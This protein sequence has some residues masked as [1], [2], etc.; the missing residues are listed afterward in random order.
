L[1]GIKG[2]EDTEP[3]LEVS[4]I[5]KRF[6]G[7]VALDSV[8]LDVRRSEIVGIV[9][10]NGAGKSTLMKILAGIYRPDSGAIR[11]DGR[12][13]SIRSP[14]EATRLGI[15]LIHQEL[16][17]V[18]SLDVAG[19]IFLGRE[20]VSWGPLKLIDR[21]TVY[22]E[23]EVYLSR[24]GLNLSPRMSLSRLSLAQQQSVEIAR[25]LSLKARLLIMD[26]PTSSLTSTETE[27]LF[28]LIRDM[29]RD[30]VS[31]IYISHRLAE[32]EDLANRVFVLRDGKNAGVLAPRE[33]T[34][35]R[36]VQLMV[37]RDLKSYYGSPASTAGDTFLQVDGIRTRRYPAQQVS[38]TIRRGEILGIAGLIGAGRS[39]V[40]QAI[41]GVKPAISGEIFLKGEQLK[42]E[43]PSDA[44]RRGIYL[45]PEDRRRFGLI[46]E[47]SVRENISLPAL[48]RHSRAGL[49]DR[50]REV[51]SARAISSELRIKMA[52]LEAVTRDLSGGNQQKVVLA[53]WLS[54]DPR[55]IVF[56]EPTKGIDIA[57]KADI[58]HLLRRLAS[59][60]VGIMMISSDLEEILGNSDR[61]A[62]MREGR[63]TGILERSECSPES[64][65]RLAVA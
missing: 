10:E 4:R 47:M 36:M 9:G 35:D 55:V 65:M 8:S 33:I 5:S 27:R 48:A 25:A 51:E 54:L 64:I 11:L 56:D 17:L 62:V 3:L 28:R 43:S 22:S 31:F 46:S 53:K 7:V 1:I 16:E 60:G 30:G 61:V 21:K 44:I 32:I 26:E 15:G 2:T 29:R 12:H 58:Y 41:C 37:G 42:I 57:A 20:A 38:L 40:A 52:S 39:E 34:S 24:L 19:N 14:G 18:D 59:E 50:K 49:I 45:I 63:I 6:P 13:V 23:T